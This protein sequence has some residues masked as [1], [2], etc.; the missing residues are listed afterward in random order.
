MQTRTLTRAALIAALYAAMTLLFAPISYGEVQIRLAESLCVL[1]IIL[2]EAVPAL[3]VGCLIANILGGCSILDI[4]FG[5]L[6]TLLAAAC[7]RR[8]RDKPLAASAMPVLFNGVI[9]GCVV[10]FAYAPAMPLALCMLFVAAGEAVSCMVIGR[11]VLAAARRLPSSLT[12][13]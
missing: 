11:F 5:T 7:T 4:V 3:A 10:H 6:A 2:P 13:R 9:V 1:P 8:L 12:M